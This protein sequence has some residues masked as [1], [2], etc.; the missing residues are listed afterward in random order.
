MTGGA[1]NVPGDSQAAQ[2]TPAHTETSEIQK[3]NFQAVGGWESEK[4]FRQVK[5]NSFNPKK[6]N[7]NKNPK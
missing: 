1:N 5:K 4:S 2:A 7:K 6:E 3:Y